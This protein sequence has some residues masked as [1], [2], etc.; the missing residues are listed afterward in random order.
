M[1]QAVLGL[2][3]NLGA[4][5][6]ILRCALHLLG[7]QPGLSILGR[8]RLYETPPLG[9]PQPDYLNAAL[10]ISFAGSA[11]ELF[12]L[13]QSVERSLGRERRERWG[14][15]TLDIDLL[16]W[17]EGPVQ[18]DLLTIP[19]PGLLTRP[20]ALAPLLDVWPE[21][22]ASLALALQEI[23]GPPPES[24]PAW[25]EPPPL[26]TVLHLA[27]EPEKAELAC[28]VAGTVGQCGVNPPRALQSVA[29]ALSGRLD[30]ERSLVQF[31][32]QMGQLTRSGLRVRDAAVTE[33]DDLTLRGFW[34]G[35]PTQPGQAEALPRV[36]LEHKPGG[37]LTLTARLDAPGREI[38]VL[39]R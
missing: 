10:R 17:S 16:H 14:A 5:R 22:P 19:H 38:L 31:V 23:G 29:F 15:R 7:A 37:Q 9:P 13:T 4:R 24:V 36:F 21:A 35:E 8:S 39:N 34:V 33:I 3:T 30:D 32:E 6:A 28:L 26:N 18:T 20:F 1:P 11:D 2:G 27:C 25:L 12:A